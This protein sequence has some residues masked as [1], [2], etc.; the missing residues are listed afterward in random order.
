VGT[1]D[2]EASGRQS[3]GREYTVGGMCCEGARR[4]L[5][6]P[7]ELDRL[8]ETREWANQ[9]ALDHGLSEDDCFQVKLAMSEAVTN[10]IIHGSN[11]V[12]DVVR[13]YAC[14]AKEALVFE[15]TDPG[16]LDTG[17]PVERLDEGGR[18]LELVS[19]VM[20]EVQLVRRDD[21]GSLRFSKR[22]ATA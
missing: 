21:G 15:V 12:T 18:G 14:K 5:E 13:I 7:A 1:G 4:E 3:K 2:R 9:V 11:Q 8:R 20:D 10:A 19:M 6:I 17:D 16:R 22:F